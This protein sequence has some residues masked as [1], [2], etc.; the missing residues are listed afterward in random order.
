MRPDPVRADFLGEE[1]HPRTGNSK[2]YIVEVN[3]HTVKDLLNMFEYLGPLSWSQLSPQT[4][5]LQ[6]SRHQ[7]VPRVEGNNYCTSGKPQLSEECFAL[8]V[9]VYPES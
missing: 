3:C 4:S 9:Y 6:I 8:E 2:K 7:L 1:V 5:G